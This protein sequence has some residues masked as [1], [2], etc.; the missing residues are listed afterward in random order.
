[1]TIEI[2]QDEIILTSKFTNKSPKRIN[3]TRSSRNKIFLFSIYFLKCFFCV[4]LYLFTTYRRNQFF[5][6]CCDIMLRTL[7]CSII[8]TSNDLITLLKKLLTY[9][10]T[11]T[12]TWTFFPHLFIITPRCPRINFL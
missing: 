1:M 7:E 5:N 8:A 11:N 3:L 4:T 9:F 10:K 6:C 12:T 2:H